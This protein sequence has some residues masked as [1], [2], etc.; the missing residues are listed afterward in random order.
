MLN[1]EGQEYGTSAVDA[2]E[3]ILAEVL[4]RGRLEFAVQLLTHL[5]E[6][7]QTG[8]GRTPGHIRQ[9]AGLQERLGGRSYVA[10]LGGVLRQHAGNERQLTLAAQYLGL[11][12]RGAVQE[13]IA[14]LGEE[15][16]RQVRARMCQVLA[17]VGPSIVPTLLGCLE[18][19][20][21][22]LV[23]NVVHVLGKIGDDAA[24]NPVVRLLGHPHMRVRI[25]ALRTLALMAPARAAR[26]ILPLS[27]DADPEV[28]L[29]AIRALGV[30]RRAEALPV[31]R[32]VAAGVA[33][34]A[35]L[36]LREEAVEALA[37]LG[38]AGACEALE[39]LA[40]R[41]VWPWQRAERR[42]RET[43]AAALA[44]RTEDED[45]SDE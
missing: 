20:R 32:D 3:E 14:L 37:T 42:L 33:G 19:P 40:R 24:F 2:F 13:L 1:A 45:P 15:R 11:V 28:R 25:E 16:D 5:G 27:R 7:L 12:A 10:L 36:S 6:A 8:G 35:D 9:L 30:L 18:D 43:A 4:T 17:K 29:E 31:L 34:P 38:T 39:A 23:R 22:F 21:W 44:A 41:R 26:P